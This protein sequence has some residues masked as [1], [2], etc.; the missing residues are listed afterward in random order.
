MSTPNW[1][2]QFQ[3]EAINHDLDPLRDETSLQRLLFGAILV[4]DRAWTIA[5]TYGVKPEWFAT[6]SY[7]T[8]WRA[9]LRLHAEGAP[10]D[11]VLLHEASGKVISISDINS[12]AHGVKDASGTEAVVKRL[13]TLWLKK[14]KRAIFEKANAILDKPHFSDEEVISEMRPMLAQLEELS[15]PVKGQN[16]V[17]RLAIQ[18]TRLT[19]RSQGTEDQSKWIETGVLDLDRKF[20]LCDP[21]KLWIIGARSH[22]GKSAITHAINYANLRRGRTVF[23]FPNEDSLEDSVTIMASQAAGVNLRELPKE[24]KDKVARFHEEFKWIAAQYEKTY[25]CWDQIREYE[26]IQA[27]IRIMLKKGVKPDLCAIDHLCRVR[28]RGKWERSDMMF[29]EIASAYRALGQSERFVALATSQLNRGALEVDR[30]PTE[31]DA[32]ESDK[33]FQESDRYWILWIPRE[34]PGGPGK[35]ACQSDDDMLVWMSVIQKKG[36]GEGTGK[37]YIRFFRPHQKP[38]PAQ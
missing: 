33:I 15:I 9:A 10:F 18:S 12:C 5:M 21:G 13:R 35:G 26:E 24:P 25:F 34:V 7:G 23:H 16:G 14:S 22:T 28:L 19:Q 2:E 27:R 1:A 20:G 32:S 4:D 29:G 6:P 17:D 11:P 30:E 3:S 8:L 38:M 31:R 37:H 36:R